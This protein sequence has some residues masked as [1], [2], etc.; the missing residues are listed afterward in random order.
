MKLSQ[1][2]LI[3]PL[4]DYPHEGYRETMQ[5]VANELKLDY[6]SASVE[7]E[8]LLKLLPTDVYEIQ[9]LYTKSFEVQAITSLEIGYVLY[10]DDYTRGE[11]LSNLNAE[12]KAVGNECGGELADHLANVL[13]L[14][15]R[16]KEQELLNDLVTL[17]V[18]P[19]VENMMKEY[20][21]SSMKQ[22]EKLYKKQYKTL[23]IP[24][25]PLGMYLHLFKALYIILESDF[26]LITENKPFEDVSFFGFL[27]NELEVEEGKKSSNS[28][29]M[30]FDGNGMPVSSCGV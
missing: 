16:I 22:K 24:S 9:E 12:H 27:K 1:Y 8:E 28:C 29:S 21:P 13:R 26:E 3:S 17:L 15:P 7:L 4:F 19:A 14:I 6:P 30:K 23:I 2:Q 20:T 10:G 11:V 25:V 5:K 18:A